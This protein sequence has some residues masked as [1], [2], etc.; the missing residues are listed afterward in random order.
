MDDKTKLKQAPA[1][2][3]AKQLRQEY[4]KRAAPAIGLFFLAPLVAEFLLGDLPISMLPALIVLAP[5]YGGGALLIREITRRKGRGWPTIFLLGTAYAVFEEAFTTQTLFNPNYLNLNLQLLQPAYVPSLGISATWTI[6]VLTLHVVWSIATSIALVEALAPERATTP[7]LGAP[8]L[9]IAVLAF[10]IG[11]ALQTLLTLRHDHFL[12][13]IPQFAVAGVIVM[14]LVATAFLTPTRA[15][16]LEPRSAPSPWRVGGISLIAGSLFLVL[17]RQWGWWALG[18]YVALD[19]AVV[20]AVSRWSKRVGW[21]PMHRLAL[22]GGVALAYGWHSF[23]QRP[24]FSAGPFLDRLTN[25]VFALS[26]AILLA[27]RQA[28]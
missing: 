8:G 22:A 15:V 25:V 20:A 7:W 13:T 24:V 12:A 1:R 9:S 3:K 6:F 10:C 18:A 5:M 14:L 2:I 28:I 19:V 27:A 16:R 23:I 4:M 17:P 26:A 21:R 11:A